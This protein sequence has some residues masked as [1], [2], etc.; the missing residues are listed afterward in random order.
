MSSKSFLDLPYDLRKKIYGFAADDVD[1]LQERRVS[2]HALGVSGDGIFQQRGFYGLTQ[3][4]RIIRREFRPIYLKDRVIAVHFRDAANYFDSQFS[5][6]PTEAE[7]TIGLLIIR[8]EAESK[9]DYPNLFH[10]DLDP[11]LRRL[12]DVPNLQFRFTDNGGSSIFNNV[13]VVHR[14]A[15]KTALEK[16][17]KHIDI[18]EPSLWGMRLVINHDSRQPWL[19]DCMK[20]WVR[21]THMPKESLE[22]FESLGFSA[23]SSHFNMIFVRRSS[24]LERLTKGIS[25]LHSSKAKKNDPAYGRLG[26]ISD[27]ASLH[28]HRPL[29]A[30]SARGSFSV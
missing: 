26:S 28:S 15:W 17:I 19:K 23:E 3:T 22:F 16:D 9:D 21:M 4:C 1:R 25:S 12:L 30:G 24:K 8:M 14:A 29:L 6:T 5:Y 11:I 13:F 27:G 10:R 20:A 7:G 2:P 18:E